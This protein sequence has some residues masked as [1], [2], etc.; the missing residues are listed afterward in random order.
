MIYKVSDIESLQ[1]LKQE[2]NLKNRI[3]KIELDVDELSQSKLEKRLNKYYF[4]CGCKEGSAAV[5][6]SAVS[7]LII[8]AFSGFN[9]DQIWLKAIIM[10]AAAAAIGKVTGLLLSRKKV[11]TIF[12]EL[13]KYFSDRLA[14]KNST[15]SLK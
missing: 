1:K 13:E 11:N 9:G 6:L 2:K 4:A 14:K 5:C 8:W 12:K 15:Y 10:V 3:R 7:F